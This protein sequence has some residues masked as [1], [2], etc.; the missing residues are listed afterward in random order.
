MSRLGQTRKRQ[1]NR[2]DFARTAVLAGASWLTFPD[3]L[4]HRAAAAGSRGNPPDTAVIQIFLSGGPSQL[5]TYDPKPDAPVEY[6]GEFRPI[7]TNVPGIDICETLP[8]QAAIMDKLALVRSV[9]HDTT[10]HYD[11][12]F[13]CLTGKR[14]KGEPSVGSITARQRG[15]NASGMPPYVRFG[16][17]PR[18]PIVEYEENHKASYLGKRYDF[19]K[20]FFDPQG[21]YEL[22]NLALQQGLPL[23]RVAD[24]HALAQQ[25][26]RLRKIM[27]TSGEA[28]AMDD[29]QRMAFDMIANP[30]VRE[31]FDLN[32]ESDILR[33]RYGRTPWCSNGRRETRYQWGQ[34]AL[35]ARRLVEA[36]VTFVTLDCDIRGGAFD[37]HQDQPRY[38]RET[39]EPMDAMI[40]ALVEDLHDRGLNDKVLVLIWGEFGR[41]P[42][43]NNEAGRDHWPS[44]M[45]VALAGGGLRTGQVIGASNSRGEVPLQRPLKPEDVLA[46]VYRHLGID[47]T[48]SFLNHAGR[49]IP[50][51][52]DGE[53]IHELL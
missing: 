12:M 23:A 52:F 42:K 5:E 28:E 2:R 38:M 17:T 50:I 40:S 3:V 27:D 21:R 53:P 37:A 49:P 47:P 14:Y 26:D 33:D 46:T 41:T 15:P 29:F 48:T 51:L 25:F 18:A 31:A 9:H 11:G 20:V 39:G 22:P 16:N 36:G 4:R 6:R 35:L 1:G 10:I 24:R 19:F 8:R 7:S 32:C 30:Q 43:I 45:S 44:V 34:A 13:L